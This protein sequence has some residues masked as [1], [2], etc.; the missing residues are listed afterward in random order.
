MRGGRDERLPS[1]PLAQMSALLSQEDLVERV[2][3]VCRLVSSYA[4]VL[5]AD[6]DGE[7]LAKAACEVALFAATLRERGGGLERWGDAT[8]DSLEPRLRGA[9]TVLRMLWRPSCATI[10]SVGHGL[11]NRVGRA[12]P[13]LDE[14]VRLTAAHPA[15]ESREM[16]PYA[17]LEDAWSAGLS[18]VSGRRRFGRLAIDRVAHPL[19]M[20]QG[21][22]YSYTHTVFYETDFGRTPLA[23]ERAA[24]VA[25]ACDAG[26]TWSLAR[27]DFDLLG[28][29]ALAAI[30]AGPGPSAGLRVGIHAMAAAWDRVGVV[31]DRAYA[32]RAGASDRRA[33]FLSIYH[34]QLVAG[35]LCMTLWARPGWLGR[36]DRPRASGPA[37][38]RAMGEW[39]ARVAGMLG[40]APAC[41]GNPNIPP[42]EH[43]G[44]QLAA[45]AV[46]CEALGDELGREI[47][48]ALPTASWHECRPDLLVHDGMRRRDLERVLQG[49]RAGLARPL[50]S[51]I[52]SA[53]SWL[54]LFVEAAETLGVQGGDRTL[55]AIRDLLAAAVD[56]QS[57]V[58]NSHHASSTSAQA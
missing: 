4:D 43:D 8:L 45:T 17:E 37:F 26:V 51:T 57:F 15:G 40:G 48:A 19:F 31:P 14:L 33:L 58:H 53:L 20:S 39:T 44:T 13:S 54:A 49:V 35:L 41:A 23:G 24:R 36:E 3:R 7:D 29:F 42:S 22:A 18:G 52:V 12:V 38:D 21:D 11:M 2:Q 6:D 25:S 56:R 9:P 55:A 27:G 47:A 34:A 5:A 28:E 1:R 10:Y 30:C 46:L 16:V 32:G 50:S